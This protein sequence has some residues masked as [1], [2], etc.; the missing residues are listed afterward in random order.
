YNANPVGAAEALKT[1]QAFTTGKRV[2]VTPG[3]VELG[4]VEA[5]QNEQFGV[6]AAQICDYV[7]LVGPQQTQAILRGLVRQQ[8]PRER[9]R[10]VK[11]LTEATSELQ[12]IVRSG[13]VVLFE[14]DLPDLY[15]EV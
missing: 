9:I 13:D 7:L 5:E 8:F 2:L 1:L 11:D 10:V 6:N 3:M 12:R 15:V 14:N 4:S